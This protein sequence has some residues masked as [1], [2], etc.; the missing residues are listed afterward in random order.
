MLHTLIKPK[1]LSWKKLSVERDQDLFVLKIPEEINYDYE[2][3]LE[4]N[5]LRLE[6]C[7]TI[8]HKMYTQFSPSFTATKRAMQFASSSLAG[9]LIRAVALLSSS[10]ITKITFTIFIKLFP[11]YYPVK[12]FPSE[13]LAKEWLDS[14]PEEKI[15]PQDVEKFKDFYAIE[16]K[17]IAT[18]VIKNL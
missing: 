16:K 12:M 13:T 1:T 18:G 7:S 10:T 3:I 5:R 17:L 2:Y 14:L 15:V 6:H 9:K 4:E 11:Q 8:K